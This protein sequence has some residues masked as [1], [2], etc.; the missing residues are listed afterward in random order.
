MISKQG[1][2]DFKFVNSFVYI[3]KCCHDRKDYF[4]T[5]ARQKQYITYLDMG[6]F[7]ITKI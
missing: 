4:N 5:R 6:K 1:L 7:V 2:V 3:S